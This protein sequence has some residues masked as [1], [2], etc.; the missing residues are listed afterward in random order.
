ML[1][2]PCVFGFHLILNIDSSSGNNNKKF[3]KIIKS[4]IYDWNHSTKKQKQ[5]S[6]KKELSCCLECPQ[7]IR[8]LSS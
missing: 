8:Y 7:N 3:H 6:L 4:F 1:L 5:M 2:I